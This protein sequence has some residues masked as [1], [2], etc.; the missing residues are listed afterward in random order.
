VQPEVKSDATPGRI[1]RSRQDD[2]LL[3]ESSEELVLVGL[4]ELAGRRHAL[5]DRPAKALDVA[6]LVALGK[7][8]WWRA[9][10]ADAP[11]GGERRHQAA[12]LSAGRFRPTCQNP[13]YEQR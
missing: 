3:E 9:R 7:R 13:Q 10:L 2:N 8:L 5:D 12:A 1:V 6:H 4:G 11:H